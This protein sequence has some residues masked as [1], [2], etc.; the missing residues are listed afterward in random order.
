M[1]REV[2]V[3]I[4]MGNTCKPMAVS[5]QCMTKST[6]KKKKKGMQATIHVFMISLFLKPISQGQITYM[7]SL[8]M[9][10]KS[11]QKHS[12]GRQARDTSKMSL[13]P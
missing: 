11:S 1:V 12:G 9:P 3:G 7:R 5:F 10:P 6:T 2:G 4:G 13:P 8:E